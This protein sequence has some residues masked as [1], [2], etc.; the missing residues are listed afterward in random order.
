MSTETHDFSAWDNEIDTNAVAREVMKAQANTGKFE[1]VPY[2]TYYVAVDDIRLDKSKQG[3]KQMVIQFVITDH[4]TLQGKLITA[5]FGLE[6]IE[7]R[8]VGFMI[9]NAQEFLRSFKTSVEIRGF[10]GF[11]ILNEY[12]N[13]IK[14]EINAN[15]WEYQLRFAQEKGYDTFTIEEKF[16][17]AEA[18]DDIPF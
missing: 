7:P 2:G 17:K 4:A 12:V 15:G 16:A 11:G 9:H 14:A 8:K 10:Q 13:A 6:H 3:R 5:F 18:S 1:K